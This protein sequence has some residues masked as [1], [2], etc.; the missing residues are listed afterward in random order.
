M[1][2][3]PD[4][5]IALRAE[6][7]QAQAKALAA[8]QL[9]ACAEARLAQERAERSDDQAQIAALKLLIEKLQ[10]GLYGQRSERKARLLDQLELELE[11]LEASA[12]EDEL[13]AEQAAAQTTSVTA[14]ARKRPARQP[15]P[16]H[17]PRERVV[18]PAPTSCPGC[19]SLRLSRLGETF[20]LE[21]TINGSTIDE[22]LAIRQAKAK[23]LVDE[24]ENWMRQ[25][26]AAMSRHATVAK[27]LDYMLTRWERFARFLTDGRICLTNNAAER[28]LRGVAL[29]R[30]AWM[31]AGSDRGGQRA[32]FMYSLMVTAKLNDIDPQAWLADVLARINDLPQT[33]LHELLPW[34]WKQRREAQ[35][36]TAA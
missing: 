10:R 2:A 15:F 25:Q 26:R 30:R 31:F 32:A 20:D 18:I 33:R 14:F 35:K 24:L 21:R 5:L 7:A 6:L 8:E 34:E 29:G 13:A 4:D 19:G 36:A 1:N 9:A 3:P 17:L 27:A 28:A 12:S 22:R 11:E 23:P 16:E